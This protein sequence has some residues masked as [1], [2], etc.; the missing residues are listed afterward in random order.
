MTRSA[1]TASATEIRTALAAR[2]RERLPELQGAVA[3]RVYSISDPRAVADPAYLQGLNGAM[4]AAIE[5]RLAVLEAGERQAPPIPTALLAHARLDARDGVSLDTVLRRY[6]AGNVLFG[7]FLVNEAERAEVPSSALRQLLAAQATVGDRLIAAVSAEYA[8]EVEN[9]PTTPAERRRETV[10]RLLAGELVDHSDLGYELD[11]H[12]LALMAKG[13]GAEELMRGLAGAVDRRLL[14]VQREEEPTWA[15]WLGGRRQLTSERA[16][17]ALGREAPEGV[18]V[19]VGEPGEGLGG[20]RFSHL[21]AKAALPIA[22]RRG[23]AVV[24]YADVALLAA[25]A[26]D[27]LIAT[28]LRG[29]YLTPLERARDGGKVARETLRAYFAAERNVSSTAAALGVDRRTVR[30]RLSAIEELLGRPI[31]GAEADLEIALRLDD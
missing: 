21:Q 26:A 12:H 15:C 8:R 3:T 11:G 2:L 14:V 24:R 9:R 6:F 29:L 27:D 5:Y 22:E 4:A 31:K 17:E 16:L 20:W 23:E 28:S 7:D 25:I 30:N 18:F 13:E 10:K 1:H 19:T